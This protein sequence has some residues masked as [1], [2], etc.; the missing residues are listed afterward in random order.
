MRKRGAESGRAVE[1]GRT[2]NARS[3]FVGVVTRL[4]NKAPASIKKAEKAWGVMVPDI[5]LGLVDE[6]TL[7]VSD[8]RM[9]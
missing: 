2:C 4:W 3:L 5:C 9:H 8:R 7:G 6:M 1:K